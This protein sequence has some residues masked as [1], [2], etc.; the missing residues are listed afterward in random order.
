M[1]SAKLPHTTKQNVFLTG[2]TGF[3]GRYLLYLLCDAEWVDEVYVLIRPKKDQT[4]EDRLE[5]VLK[6]PLFVKARDMGTKF[7]NIYCVPGDLLQPR[8]GMSEDSIELIAEKVTMVIHNAAALS[9]AAGLQDALINNT[10]PTWILYQLCKNRF[11]LNPSFILVSTIATNSHLPLVPEKVTEFSTDAKVI[12]EH[13]KNMDADECVRD[14]VELKENRLDGYAFSKGLVEKM[15]VD[16]IEANGSTIPVYFVRPGGIISALGGPLPG[17]L[18]D[19]CFYGQLGYYVYTGKIY[20]FLCNKECD[21]NMAPV[22]LVSNL[23]MCCCLE[24]SERRDNKSEEQYQVRVVNGSKPMI[25]GVTF[26]CIFKN[27]RDHYD[28][29]VKMMYELEPEIP[30]RS[31][32][33]EPIY[34]ES[35]W[36]FNL[37]FNILIFFP[38]FIYSLFVGRNSVKFKKLYK[39]MNF[40]YKFVAVLQPYVTNQINVEN[41]YCDVLQEKYGEVYPIESDITRDDFMKSFLSGLARFLIPVLEK[42]QLK[43][44]KKLAES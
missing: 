26:G 40:I 2:V 10:T 24:A 35:V 41:G 13:I 19:T 3:V 11:K 32:P 31:C 6:D 12:Y 7:E 39:L 23:I 8:L 16:D 34:L 33:W 42:K 37:I 5:G 20:M 17:W 36:L 30:A 27:V 29:M 38:L 43:Y 22:D 4:P 28:E 21:I 18:H 9:F 1:S 15:I 25:E 14:M 44:K